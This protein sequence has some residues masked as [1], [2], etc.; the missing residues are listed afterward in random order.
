M[1]SIKMMLT[2][3]PELY[4]GKEA[5]IQA[6][7]GKF[8]NKEIKCSNSVVQCTKCEFYSPPPVLCVFITVGERVFNVLSKN[9]KGHGTIVIS[10]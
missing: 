3:F 4:N 2:L 8:L 1:A 9:F 5:N 7:L 6:G 10:H